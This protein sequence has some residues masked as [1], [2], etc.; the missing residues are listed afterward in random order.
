MKYLFICKK[1]IYVR[2]EDLQPQEKIKEAI[3]QA[4]PYKNM[5]QSNKA[6]DVPISL[7]HTHDGETCPVTIQPDIR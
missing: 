1:G 7:F 6:D 2:E 5:D 4:D 3:D